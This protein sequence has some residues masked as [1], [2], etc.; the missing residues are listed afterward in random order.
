ML[1]GEVKIKISRTNSTNKSKTK[2]LVFI[3]HGYGADGNDI[4]GIGDQW[5]NLFPEVEFIAPTAPYICDSNQDGY[6][7]F[8]IPIVDKYKINNEIKTSAIELNDF[9]DNELDIRNLTSSD[10]SIVGFSQG[11]MMALYLAVTRIQKPLSVISFSGLMLQGIYIEENV[12]LPS[13]LMIH[14]DEDLVVSPEYMASSINYFKNANI[15]IE[16]HLIQGLGHGIDRTCI[17]IGASFLNARI[18]TSK[19]S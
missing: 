3:L 1:K 14:G 10:M 7:W 15:N 12:K 13:I 19:D 18:N 5:N 16:S 4:I 17:S 11:G 6:Q 8:K 9:I 2:H